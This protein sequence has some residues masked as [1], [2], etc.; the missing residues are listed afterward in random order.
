MHAP[1]FKQ[2][3]NYMNLKA[4]TTESLTSSK[5]LDQKDN[6]RRREAEYEEKKNT[7]TN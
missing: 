5:A 1:Q 6:R 7:K 2:A 3:T 4:M